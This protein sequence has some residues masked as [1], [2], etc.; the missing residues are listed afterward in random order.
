MAASSRAGE[1]WG[2]ARTTAV[3]WLGAAYAQAAAHPYATRAAEA[4]AEARA[5][6]HAERVLSSAAVAATLEHAHAP[7]VLGAL[8]S[9]LLWA[10][11]G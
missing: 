7:R 1:A 8:G 6:P 11:W 3:A 5:H 10:G 2:E 9:L 4:L